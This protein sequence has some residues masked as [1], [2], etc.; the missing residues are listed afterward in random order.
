MINFNFSLME[1]LSDKLRYLNGM[2]VA[3]TAAEYALVKLPPWLYWAYY[4]IRIAR[5]TA[6]R[7][8]GIVKSGDNCCKLDFFTLFD[9]FRN[10]ITSPAMRPKTVLNSLAYSE[11]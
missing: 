5:W 1:S 9:R 11:S 2:L 8:H 4:P 7:T 3:P 10:K 6:S